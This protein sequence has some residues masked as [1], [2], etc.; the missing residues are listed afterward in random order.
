MPVREVILYPD[1]ILRE[2]SLEVTIFDANLAIE[3]SDLIETM[4]A[5]PGVAIAAPQIGIKRR[6]IA[7]DVTA[8]TPKD[9]GHGELVLINPIITN[10]S[11][12]KTVREGCLSIPDYLANL[13]RAKKVTVKAFDVNSEEVII[14]ARGLEAI[15]L[16]HEIDHLDGILFIDRV[17][18]IR[19]LL[20]RG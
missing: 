16:Q 14:E 5:T 15:A 9:T 1:P 7:L 18:S 20:K 6:I 12:I 2:R 3:V 10:S 17:T 4:R 11:Q 13:K 8:K 19:D